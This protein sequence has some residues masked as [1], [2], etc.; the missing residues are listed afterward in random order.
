[1]TLRI[2]P[3]QL[4]NS[5][6]RLAV[7]FLF[8]FACKQGAEQPALS[9]EKVAR[10]MADLYIAEAA[11]YGLT[12]YQKDSLTH[13]YYDQVLQIHR[14]TK[15]EYEK[16]LRLLAQDVPRMEG[17]MDRVKVMLEPNEKEK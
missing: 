13:F 1:M 17:I 5:P 6:L 8:L 11:T 9:D 4:W 14:V 3:G 7:V 2:C 15:E 12:G 10:I 16:N